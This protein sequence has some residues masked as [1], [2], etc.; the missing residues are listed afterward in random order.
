MREKPIRAVSF[1]VTGTLV[2]CPRLGD[3]YSEVLNRHGIELEPGWI[4]SQFKIV[5]QEIDCATPLGRDRF[6]YSG[7]AQEWWGRLISRLCAYADQPSPTRFAVAEL[8]QRFT[9]ADAWEIYPDVQ[10]SLKRLE[11]AG[12]RLAVASNWDPR[13]RSL[14]EA[15]GLLERF[16]VC[17]TSSDVG[18]AKPSPQIFDRLA[19]SLELQTRQIAHVGDSTIE[20]FEGAH[21]AGLSSVLLERRRG[22]DLE[23]VVDVILDSAH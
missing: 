3:I 18:W 15:L 2:A 8:Y 23:G 7:D 4:A 13:L 10:P 20:D 5:F 14:L 17:T 11:R 21:A 22:D 12:L 9:R 1:D 6:T 16:T 19:R